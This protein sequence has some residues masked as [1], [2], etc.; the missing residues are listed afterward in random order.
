MRKVI[1]L[2]ALILGMTLAG[3]GGSPS[4]T[5]REVAQFTKQVHA[6]V[7]YMEQYTDKDDLTN[8]AKSVCDSFK[9]GQSY[10]N[11][12]DTVGAYIRKDAS[13]KEVDDVIKVALDTSCPELKD[14]ALG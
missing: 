10:G 14:K 3:C 6:K 13:T 5:D 12:S 8:L 9:S 11:V 1:A 4:V 7:P 2:P